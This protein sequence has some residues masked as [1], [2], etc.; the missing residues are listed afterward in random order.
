[1]FAHHCL[2]AEK[3]VTTPSHL[4]RKNFYISSIRW[5]ACISYMWHCYC[6]AKP[7]NPR[8]TYETRCTVLEDQTAKSLFWPTALWL[9]LQQGKWRS[10]SSYW[11]RKSCDVTMCRW[12][13]SSGR[14]EGLLPCSQTI[15]AVPCWTPDDGREAR[16]IPHC[17][18]S[19]LSPAVYSR[20]NSTLLFWPPVA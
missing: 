17:L 6:T 13:N 7:L 2:L 14:F 19:Y 10:H 5:H 12:V 11:K 9:T 8:W 20:H 15:P 4:S 1:M 18:I 16:A 3:R